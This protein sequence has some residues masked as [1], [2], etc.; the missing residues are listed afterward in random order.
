MRKSHNLKQFQNQT[1]LK[2]RFRFDLT[3]SDCHNRTI[4]R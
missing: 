3:L 4:I 1:A 2:T